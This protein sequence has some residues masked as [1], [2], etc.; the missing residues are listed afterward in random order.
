MERPSPTAE[1]RRE[2]GPASGDAITI[3]CRFVALDGR[4]GGCVSGRRRLVAAVLGSMGAPRLV[5]MS[6]SSTRMRLAIGLAQ[7]IGR[8]VGVHLC[9]RQ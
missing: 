1:A 6:R 4:M 3:D 2:A 7:S 8:D 9:G 5:D